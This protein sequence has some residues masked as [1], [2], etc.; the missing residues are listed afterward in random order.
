MKIISGI[1]DPIKGEAIQIVHIP[2]KNLF[3]V[4]LHFDY[5]DVLSQ[6]KMVHERFHQ[7]TNSS[8]AIS[9]VAGDFNADFD[10]CEKFPWIGYQ[11]VFDETKKDDRIPS[12][13]PDPLNN[14]NG[15]VSIDHIYY[16]PKKLLCI[17]SGKAFD[18][19]DRTS[20]DTLHIFGSDHIYIWAHFD[21][22]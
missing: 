9:L 17:Q 15:N 2:S 11:S 14:E 13:Y 10:L 18:R 21:L 6:A 7:L 20:E 16:N 5:F 12:Y 1:L 22:L 3:L 4:N 19:K 8:D